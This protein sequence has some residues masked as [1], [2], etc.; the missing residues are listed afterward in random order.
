MAPEK[1]KKCII[2]GE[3]EG[4]L[5]KIFEEKDTYICPGCLQKLSDFLKTYT[6]K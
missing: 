3:T 2:C 1:E 5:R 6:D 4:E